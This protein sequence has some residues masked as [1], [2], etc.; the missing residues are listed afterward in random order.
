[1]KTAI[2]IPNE[3]FRE[4]EDLARRQKKSRSELYAQAVAEYVA[5]H[6]SDGI[7]EALNQVF[8]DLGDQRDDFVATA[9]RRILERT[10]W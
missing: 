2:S 6:S 9:A 4:A 10:E 1:M 5:R 3:V 7:T 8:A